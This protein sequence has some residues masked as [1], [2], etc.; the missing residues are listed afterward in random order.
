[1][2]IDVD[3]TQP[4]E[5]IAKA[6]DGADP[7]GAVASEDN[8]RIR[9]WSGPDQP[10]DLAGTVDDRLGVRRSAARRSATRIEAVFS[11]SMS[12]ARDFSPALAA[13]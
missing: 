1:V 8:N 12:R 2:P 5:A 6:G 9:G 11:S 4:L 7:D 10:S 3:D 13:I